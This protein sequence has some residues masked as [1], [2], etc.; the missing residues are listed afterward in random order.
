[1]G[2]EAAGSVSRGFG[3]LRASLASV[4]EGLW[5]CGAVGPSL[6]SPHYAKGDRPEG[7]PPGIAPGVVL[8]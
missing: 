1:M 4:L 6:P 8:L 3:R 2:P 5:G 7:H